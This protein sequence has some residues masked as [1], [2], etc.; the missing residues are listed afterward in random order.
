MSDF[1][2]T[3]PEYAATALLDKLR[4]TDYSYLDEGGHV[5][6]DYTGAGLAAR[7]QL[8]AHDD[9]LRTGCYGN[10]HSDNPTSSASTRLVDRAR[11]AVL[12]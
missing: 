1:N 12:R 10:P 4:A 8:R 11:E 9:R 7:S 2:A 5:Y 3:Y 6:L